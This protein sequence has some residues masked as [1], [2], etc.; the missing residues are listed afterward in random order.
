MNCF[1]F[2]V[3]LTCA[4]MCAMPCVAADY[5]TYIGDSYAYSVSAIATDGA[6]NTYA[7]GSRAVVASTPSALTDVFVTKVDPSGNVT[8]LA[9]LSGSAIDVGS[10]IAVDSMGNIYFAGNTT[11]PDFPLQL[12]L[13]SSISIAEGVA[14]QTGF[15][16]KLSPTGAV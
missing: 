9:T 15:L 2:L 12:P 11:S 8:L 10:S 6:G 14:Q 13:Q 5:A 1:R 16:A 4:L 3:P 7:T